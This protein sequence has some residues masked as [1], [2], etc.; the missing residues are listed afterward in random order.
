MRPRTELALGLGL[1]LAL[2]IAA[3]SLGRRRHPV[4]S[5]DPRRSTLLTGPNGAKGFSD[6]LE[7]LGVRVERYRSRVILLEE[8][9]R[10][11]QGA[12]PVLAFLDPSIPLDA[13]EASHLLKFTQY[14]DLL[15]AGPSAEAAMRCFGFGVEF[16]AGD[17]SQTIPPGTVRTE[18]SP[19]VQAVLAQSTD[20]VVS[21]SSGS[22][23]ATVATCQVLH[24]TEVDTLL[25]STGGRVVAL[26]LHGRT[27]RGSSVTLVADGGLFG[28][29]EMRDTDAGPFALGL[30]A[31]RYQRVIFDEQ[32]HG[33]GPAGGLLSAML[34]WSTRS[35]WGWTA[36]QL[37]V[38]GLIALL[39]GVVRFG[40]AV[41]VI[42]RKRRSPLEHVRALATALAA[43]RGHDVAVGA[44]VGGLRRRLSPAGH[45][46]RGDWHPWLAHLSTQLRTARARDAADSLNRLTLPGQPADSVLRA[47]NAVEDVWEE[48]RP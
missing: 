10:A 13:D 1:L 28:N 20:T 47:A 19:W 48:L 2:G 14:G 46:G 7:R 40:P 41:P 42:E 34:A 29:R 21:D 4:P 15:L 38:T 25:V 3:S 17:S 24:F 39:A 18:Q 44:I 9:E 27:D 37:A 11:H 5:E 12:P 22:E 30:I 8:I 16:R 23:D 36:W 32:H 35:P 45:S 33:F 6:A 31:G 26:R 43:A